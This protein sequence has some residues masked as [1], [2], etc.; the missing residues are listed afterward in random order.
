[1]NPLPRNNLKGRHPRCHY[2][3]L[4]KAKQMFFAEESAEKYLR[5]INLKDYT[6]YQC[7]YCNQY[8]IAH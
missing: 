3:R 7:K 5:K 4:G 8:H 2:N 1:M 6:I